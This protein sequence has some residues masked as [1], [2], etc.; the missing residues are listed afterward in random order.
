MRPNVKERPSLLFSLA[1]ILI[2]AT[3][4]VSLT[5]CCGGPQPDEIVNSL[6]HE[7]EDMV[8]CDTEIVPLLP[9]DERAKWSARFRAFALRSLTLLAWAKD[10]EVDVQAAHAK[11]FAKDGE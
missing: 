3:L 9:E 1:M 8:L 10:E 7:V 5:G 6:Q 2:G 11:L 4:V